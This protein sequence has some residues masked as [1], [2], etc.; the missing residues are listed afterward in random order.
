VGQFLTA[1][2]GSALLSCGVAGAEA[3]RVPFEREPLAVSKVE[4]DLH[5]GRVEIVV[6]GMVEPSLEISAL[7][8]R[9]DVAVVLVTEA[10]GTLRIVQPYGETRRDPPLLVRLVLS[11]SQRLAL[12]GRDLDVSATDRRE[13][14][15]EEVWSRLDEEVALDRA[16]AMRPGGVASRY[17]FELD[18]SSV[19]M[20][21]MTGG[22]L[23]GF[24]SRA[25]LTGCRGPFVF[26]VEDS[27]VEVEDHWGSLYL[28]GRDSG[29]A[30]DVLD[31]SVELNLDA[32]ELRAS[33]G[34]GTL[35]GALVGGLVTVT[36]WRGPISLDGEETRVTAREL[37][38]EQDF[39]TLRGQANQLFAEDVA[40]AVRATMDGGRLEARSVAG[41]TMV[42]GR[43]A[44]DLELVE[45]ADS[46]DLDL[47]D[48]SFARVER[49]E[50]PIEATV[51]GSELTA[52]NVQDLQLRGRD[53]IVSVGDLAGSLDVEMAA[54]LFDARASSRSSQRL[55]FSGASEV[56]FGVPTPCRVNLLGDGGRGQAPPGLSPGPCELPTRRTR[57]GYG[58]QARPVTV[59]LSMTG[60]AQVE[61]WGR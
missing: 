50:G 43:A 60:E 21:S 55:S 57:S 5:G 2:V 35:S 3:V 38:S 14:L 12:E 42:Q 8:E 53:A 13:E 25:I 9:R 52:Q 41:R 22:Q 48:R 40:G 27:E 54:T 56:R 47:G 37:L 39:L 10:E 1:V 32:S 59:H 31:G 28:R 11:P 46:V 49:V 26:D 17:T 36:R 51:N 15:A 44:A 16:Q 18:G 20:D 34:R 4:L 24:G 7:T 45:L 30:V 58:G 33:E 23:S 29:F 6:D 19:T 61:L